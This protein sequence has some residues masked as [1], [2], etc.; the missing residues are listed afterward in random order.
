MFGLGSE[1]NE[2]EAT[3]VWSSKNIIKSTTYKKNLILAIKKKTNMGYSRPQKTLQRFDNTQPSKKRKIAEQLEP[4]TQ[5]L[6]IQSLLN[7]PL[8]NPQPILIEQQ[9]ITE[10]SPSKLNQNSDTSELDDELSINSLVCENKKYFCSYCQKQ[11]KTPQEV[12]QHNKSQKHNKNVFRAQ[13]KFKIGEE[14]ITNKHYDL[15]MSEKGW[16][17]DSVCIGFYFE[18]IQ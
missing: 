5:T 17:S 18:Y 1:E 10:K 16:L 15:L 13:T 3:S 4:T 8:T 11:S 12:N 2:V 7:Q 9:Q 14:I 6:T